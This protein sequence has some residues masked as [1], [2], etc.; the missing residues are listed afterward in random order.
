MGHENGT[1]MMRLVPLKGKEDSLLPLHG[2]AP[3]KALCAHNEM[4][5]ICKAGGEP[6]PRTES[7]GTLILDF[8]ACRSVQNKCMSVV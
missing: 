8:S 6:V 4:T 2:C 5:V 3:K 1:L 7:S